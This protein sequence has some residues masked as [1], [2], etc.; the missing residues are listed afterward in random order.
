MGKLVIYY[1][2][3]YSR[4]YPKIWKNL[5]SIFQMNHAAKKSNAKDVE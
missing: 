2:R 5:L 1:T 3:E 4:K